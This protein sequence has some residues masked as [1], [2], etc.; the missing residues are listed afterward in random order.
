MRLRHAAGRRR[1]ILG[2]STMFLL[3]GCSHVQQPEV[4]P[5]S[6]PLET[7]SDGILPQAALRQD[8]RELTR[9]LDESHPDPIR[10]AAVASRSIAW[11]TK[12]NRRS[13]PEA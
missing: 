8:L 2:L 3:L 5:E 9:L 1:V 12:S 4:A 7:P 6:R 10:A 13:L 11:S